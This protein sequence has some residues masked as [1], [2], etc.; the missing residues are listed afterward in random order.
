MVQYKP[1]QEAFWTMN[2]TVESSM[3]AAND[4][5][6]HGVLATP[7]GSY[8]VSCSRDR[9]LASRCPR[10]TCTQGGYHPWPRRWLAFLPICQRHD[11]G[12]QTPS[13]RTCV[14]PGPWPRAA[15]SGQQEQHGCQVLVRHATHLPR[16]SSPVPK[17]RMQRQCA[18]FFSILPPNDKTVCTVKTCLRPSTEKTS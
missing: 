17:T 11:C 18:H 13:A 12:R 7:R 14:S 10:R 3:K 2:N 9:S 4:G 15:R 5:D 1:M 16:L 6:R 8:K